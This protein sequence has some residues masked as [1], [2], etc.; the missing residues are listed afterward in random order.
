M[1]AHD[2]STRFR[3]VMLAALAAPVLGACGGIADDGDAGKDALAPLCDGVAIDAGAVGCNGKVIQLSSASACGIDAPPAVPSNVCTNLCGG[4]NYSCTYDSS[5]DLLTCQSFCT[6]RLPSGL[7]DD[8]AGARADA[9]GDWLARAAYLE[10]AAVDAFAIL[11]AELG[12][13]GA[14][15]ALVRA[16]E[17]AGAD[18]VRHA[19]EMGAL[20]RAFG[21]EPAVPSVGPRNVRAVAEIA[22]ENAI[23]GCVRE[24]FGALVATWQAEH[25]SDFRVRAAMK[26]IARDETR[27]AALGWRV[28]DWAA[29]RLGSADRLH[30]EH[31]MQ[32]AV[33]ELE[34]A[35]R[36]EPDRR[37]ARTLGL[38]N[39]REALALVAA[40]R[41]ELWQSRA[42]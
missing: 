4:P 41:S 26:R 14:P 8:F 42:A 25:A 34:A 28:F 17:R 18:E 38:P 35:N 1:H 31:A 20:A 22:L 36:A 6:G 12:A 11:A 5:T 7:R 13:H 16:A 40:M 33:A 21:G 10:A 30:V 32:V 15:R 23:E 9:V 27:H 2:L 3:R 37:L 24:T 39:S 19:R 29:S